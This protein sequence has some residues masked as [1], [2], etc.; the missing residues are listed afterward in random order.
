MNKVIAAKKRLKW[1]A[2][3]IIMVLLGLNIDHLPDCA[4]SLQSPAYRCSQA[5][6]QHVDE[7]ANDGVAGPRDYDYVG[8]KATERLIL[9]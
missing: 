3:C 1:L 7:K 4:T 9:R 2:I 8:I 5:E 6:A